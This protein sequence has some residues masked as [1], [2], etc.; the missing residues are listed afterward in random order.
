MEEYGLLP[1]VEH[2]A[3][4]R[5]DFLSYLMAGN[6]WPYGHSTAVTIRGILI[7]TPKILD[8]EDKVVHAEERGHH[9][10]ALQ[11]LHDYV[12]TADRAL[13]RGADPQAHRRDRRGGAERALPHR[14]S[15]RRSATS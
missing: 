9:D 1:R 13:R 10:A 11:K 5:R 15:I 8:F 6:L 2:A 7:T 14:A 4:I 3:L 12:W